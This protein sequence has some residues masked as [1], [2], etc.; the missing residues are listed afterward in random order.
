ML[1]IITNIKNSQQISTFPT[2]I[3]IDLDY[4]IKKKKKEKE[5]LKQQTES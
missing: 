4:S 5:N 1:Y 3:F 2:P